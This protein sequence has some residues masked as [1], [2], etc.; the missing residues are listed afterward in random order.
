MI[1]FTEWLK[2]Y[3]FDDVVKMSKD[4]GLNISNYDRNEL[5]LGVNTEKEHNKDKDTDVVKRPSDVLKIAIAHLRE[6]PKYYTKLKKVEG[7]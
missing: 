5:V 7:K 3:N 1:L 4:N 6:D 2:R